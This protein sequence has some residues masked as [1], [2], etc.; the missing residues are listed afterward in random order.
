MTQLISLVFAALLSFVI[1]SSALAARYIVVLKP[2]LYQSVS[3]QEVFAQGQSSKKLDA[4]H[5]LIIETENPKQIESIQKAEG[6]LHIEKERFFKA[7]GRGKNK[8][9]VGQNFS[10]N[11]AKTPKMPWGIEAVKAPQAW[12]YSSSGAYARVAILDTGIDKDHPALKNNFEIG[13]DFYGEN[14]SGKYTFFDEVGHGTHV[15]GTIA[16]NQMNA[17]FVGVAPQ[18]KILAGR[19]CGQESCSSLAIVEGINWAVKE[20]VDVIN[21]SLGGGVLSKADRIALDAAEAAGVVV[22]AA[23][24]NDGIDRIEYPARYQKVISVGAVDSDLKRAEFSQYGP[25]LSIVGPG[26]EVISS[27]PMG[28][29]AEVSSSFAFSNMTKSSKTALMDG[30]LYVDGLQ[31]ADLV[32][33]GLGNEVDFQGQNLKN[34]Y[35]LIQRGEISFAEKVEFATQAGASGVVIYNNKEDGVFKGAVS[36]PGETTTIPAIMIEKTLGD[37]IAAELQKNQTVTAHV[38]MEKVD[39]D[40]YE[41]TSMATPHVAGVVALMKSANKKLTPAQVRQILAETAHPLESQE[42][43]YGAGLVNAEAAVLKANAAR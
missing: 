5:S 30:S 27:V 15:A 39:Y 9:V 41:G 31:K 12:T 40:Q 24:G 6:V 36:E 18:A 13:K 28:T 3:S 22:V 38:E 34:K 35:A 20:K 42:N 32:F 7:P 1:S 4:V 26:V 43:E 11:L 10:Y 17:G 37:E 21:M 8:P 33:A 16:A 25:E 14:H 2:D 19:V 23:S 29:A